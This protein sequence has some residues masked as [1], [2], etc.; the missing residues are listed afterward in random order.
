M[1]PGGQFPLS[2]DRRFLQRVEEDPAENTPEEGLV[3]RCDEALRGFERAAE[4]AVSRIRA[5]AD[6]CRRVP[7]GEWND[8][9]LG[10]IRHVL[11]RIDEAREVLDDNTLPNDRIEVVRKGLK[12]EEQQVAGQLA[13]EARDVL[14]Q[15]EAADL[16]VDM[17]ARALDE[18]R[19]A[20]SLGHD[21]AAVSLERLRVVAALP[22]A[23]RAPARVDIEAV[24]EVLVDLLV[25][26]LR[27]DDAGQG[28]KDGKPLLITSGAERVVRQ[29]PVVLP[30]SRAA[31]G[32][33]RDVP[34]SHRKRVVPIT[35]RRPP[36]GNGS[37]SVPGMNAGTSISPMPQHPPDDRDSR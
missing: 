32:R 18:L 20:Q 2:R 31:A 13:S 15:L 34:G 14:G 19:L 26:L 24:A 12:E 28:R 30:G 22:W 5:V 6:A 29:G 8:A 16:P 35:V 9:A 27:Q 17:L 4:Q 23:A 37:R 11:Q 36:A 1:S 21:A 10:R 3:A 25:V 33:P 7:P